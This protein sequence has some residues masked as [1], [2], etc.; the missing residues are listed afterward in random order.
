MNYCCPLNI[1]LASACTGECMH[2]RVHAWDCSSRRIRVE[3][4]SRNLKRCIE[5]MKPSPWIDF[6]GLSFADVRSLGRAMG[7]RSEAIILWLAPFKSYKETSAV[8]SSGACSSG[9]CS[10]E[11]YTL[12]SSAHRFSFSF[13][14][15]LLYCM[16]LTFFVGSGN[17]I[18][19]PSLN[20]HG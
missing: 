7:L 3:F 16:F 6:K 10:L 4:M 15:S 2:L 12:T 13:L 19:W 5:K 18:C 9:A 11:N 17:S 20:S 1:A 14:Y 8:A